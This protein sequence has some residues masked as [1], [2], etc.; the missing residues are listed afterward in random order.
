MYGLI[1]KMVA[2][3]GQREALVK[4]LLEGCS[5]MPGCLSY[6][7]AQDPTDVCAIWVTEV[8]DSQ[9][10][11]RAASSLPSVQRAI[12]RGK[13]LIASFGGLTVTE[14]LGGCGLNGRSS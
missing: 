13:P 6:I 9:Q 4:I 3:S 5:S 2:A 7:V 11:Q 14:P 10:S 1:E 12:E 8:W